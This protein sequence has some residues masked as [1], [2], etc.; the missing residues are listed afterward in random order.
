[1]IGRAAEG[2]PEGKCAVDQWGFDRFCGC[3]GDEFQTQGRPGLEAWLVADGAEDGGPLLRRQVKKTMDGRH[4]GVQRG[5]VPA[6]ADEFVNDGDIRVAD[7]QFL[8]RRAVAFGEILKQRK[9]AGC[10]VAA[11]G[12]PE[13]VDRVV[14]GEFPKGFGPFLVSSREGEGLFGAVFVDDGFKARIVQKL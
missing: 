11:A 5:P 9:K 13:D 12:A 6:R 7:E 14:G 8:A 3:I 4:Y 10:A 1:M 2:R